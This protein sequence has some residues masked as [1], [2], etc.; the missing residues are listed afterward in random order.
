MEGKINPK[1]LLVGCGKM[2]GALLSG[3]LDQRQESSNINVVEPQKNNQAEFIGRNVTLFNSL[4]EIDIDYN[5]DFVLFAVKPQIMDSVIPAY[6]RFSDN[7]T[8]ISIA[9]GKTINYFEKKLGKHSA[10]IRAMPNTPAAIK[11]GITVACGNSHVEKPIQL[12]CLTL[13]AAVGKV[14]WLDDEK[15]IDAVTAISGSGP[16]YVFLLAETMIKAAID[17]GLEHQ[18]ARD[19]T[20]HTIAGSGA[21]LQKSA[22]NAS[23]L[24][25]NVTSPGGTTEA[26]LSILTGKN[27]MQPLI[28]KAVGRAIMRSK[29]LDAKISPNK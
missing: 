9:A 2:G 29:D 5:P 23:T 16:A 3:W 7:S 28:S 13:L 20:I 14:C 8:F 12:S 6:K 26:A 4:D 19:L 25:E 18:I 27:G 15:L 22:D 1:I 17:A 11:R 21:L 24:R 10:I